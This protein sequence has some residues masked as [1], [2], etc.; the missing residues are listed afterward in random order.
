MY[1]LLYAVC[2][3]SNAA[4][5]SNPVRFFVNCPPHRP[6]VRSPAGFRAA[7][8][9][10]GG[11]P[12]L[13]LCDGQNLFDDK[14]SFSGTSWRAAETAA[15]LIAAGQVPP[16]VIVGIDHSGTMRSYDYLP[17]DPGAAKGN[18]RCASVSRWMQ[19][20]VCNANVHLSSLLA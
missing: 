8:A 9:P 1:R 15:K 3:P 16:F 10:P 14:L 17:Y 5:R 11:Y 19:H 6:A 4:R 18:A 12:V 7:A 20:A 13:Y 2:M